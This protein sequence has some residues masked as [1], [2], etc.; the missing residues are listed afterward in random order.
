[1]GLIVGVSVSIAHEIEA[2]DLKRL[3]VRISVKERLRRF[4]EDVVA[5]P[6]HEAGVLFVVVYEEVEE[7]VDEVRFVLVAAEALFFK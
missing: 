4:P 3:A 5:H 1:V 7:F 2:H 6:L